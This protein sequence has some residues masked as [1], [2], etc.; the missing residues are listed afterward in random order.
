M[1]SRV[2]KTDEVG[3]HGEF[4]VLSDNANAV[5]QCFR[6]HRNRALAPDEVRVL[7]GQVKWDVKSAFSE[8]TETG[9]IVER[10]G[11]VHTVKDAV[12]EL[13]AAGEMP[14]QKGEKAVVEIRSRLS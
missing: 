2:D 12:P 9:N 14:A 11:E 3:V 7:L 6:E 10:P 1:K 4:H 5:L 13:L 8:L